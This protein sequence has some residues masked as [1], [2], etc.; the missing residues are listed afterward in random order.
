MSFHEIS[1]D[2]KNKTESF[3]KKIFQIVVIVKDVKQTAKKYIDFY[4]IGQ[5][6][7]YN[8][9]PDRIDSMTVNG[10]SQNHSYIMACTNIGDIE[11]EL[12]Q[13][14]Y[15]K[16][17]YNEFTNNFGEGLQHICFDVTDYKGA[18]KLLQS[19]KYKI[20]QSGNWNNCT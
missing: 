3:F 9:G 15:D 20:L 6:I 10:I 4:N 11:L 8:I 16:S 1:A 2:E 13:P 5:W 18:L 12:I 17:I 19:K 7:F 14:L